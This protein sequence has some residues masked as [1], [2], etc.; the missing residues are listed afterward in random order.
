[1]SISLDKCTYFLPDELFA[2]AG[3]QVHDLQLGR[4]QGAIC[5]ELYVR[6]S[7]LVRL[8]AHVTQISN[9]V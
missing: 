3:S 9:K 5:C 7:L 1:M 6:L 8:D 2:D 4:L